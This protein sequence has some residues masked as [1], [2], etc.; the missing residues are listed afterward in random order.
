L[1]IIKKMRFSRITSSSSFPSSSR[2]G[3]T[4]TSSSST[5]TDVVGPPTTLVRPTTTTT[6]RLWRRSHN[7]NSAS[8]SNLQQLQ[9]QQ[10]LVVNTRG[11]GGSGN[12]RRQY[13]VI[14]SSSIAVVYASFFVA[15][16]PLVNGVAGVGPRGL[17]AA[18]GIFRLATTQ[19]PWNKQQRRRRS[20]AAATKQQ[21]QQQR[22]VH[23]TETSITNSNNSTTISCG[24]TSD[25]TEGNFIRRSDCQ[26]YSLDVYDEVRRIYYNRP[27]KGCRRRT[28][29]F[30]GP[31]MVTGAFLNDWTCTLRGGDDDDAA[32]AVP[33][34][35]VVSSSSSTTTT[36][37]TT[38]E[39]STAE[40]NF[41]ET[42]HADVN[43]TNY[44]EMKDDDDDENNDEITASTIAPKRLHSQ[45]SFT[46][47]SI[48]TKL[49]RTVTPTQTEGENSMEDEIENDDNVLTDTVS[50]ATEPIIEV[51]SEGGLSSNTIT[52]YNSS[53]EK[54][55]FSLYQKGDGSEDDID[56]I[57][58]RYMKMQMNVRERA[59]HSLEET[60]QWRFEH[61]IDTMIGRPR[62]NFQICKKVFPHYFAGYDIN[63]NVAFVQRP[64]LLNLELAKVNGLT[65]EGLLGM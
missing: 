1:I 53:I 6:R 64:A 11:S 51:E 2:I 38:T 15:K 60:I 9:Q 65:N 55:R 61:N 58:I 21:Q 37:T 30:I 16:V 4:I 26:P 25:W 18:V 5:A 59:K 48:L 10:Q 57:P 23:R 49:P 63:G 33:T 62:P 41:L 27:R 29:S 52:T 3:I 34:I 44:M 22:S 14:V 31:T 42:S 43:T 39:S 12:R 20:A 24:D 7:Y 35:A 8:N 36:T 40:S 28:N 56:K 17:L 19:R 46:N 45:D 54:Y 32:E 50:N 47:S 13:L